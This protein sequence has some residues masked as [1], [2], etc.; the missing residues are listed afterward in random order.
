MMGKPVI[1]GAPN[2]DELLTGSKPMLGSVADARIHDS[3]FE[4]VIIRCECGEKQGAVT[5]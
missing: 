1:S 4:T 2:R 5:I 3:Q